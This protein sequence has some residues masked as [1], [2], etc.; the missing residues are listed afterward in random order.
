MKR[1]GWLVTAFVSTTVWFGGGAVLS[2]LNFLNVS[3]SEGRF[4][5]GGG[6]IIVILCIAIHVISIMVREHQAD[7]GR[8]NAGGRRQ[9]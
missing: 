5:L 3:I 8:Y 1:T 6:F 9:G 2:S 4:I 7:G